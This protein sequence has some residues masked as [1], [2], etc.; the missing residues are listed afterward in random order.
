MRTG[1]WLRAA[2]LAG[3]ALTGAADA[4]RVYRVQPGDTLWSLAHANGTTVANLLAL[5]PRPAATLRAGEVILLPDREAADEVVTGEVAAPVT[6]AGAVQVGQAVYYPGRP[7]A[8]TAMTAAHLT[9]PKGTWVRVTHRVTGRSVDVLINDRG[10]FGV[11]SRIIDLSAAAA[12]K[13]GILSEGVA[14]VTVAVLARP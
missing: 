7:D 2:L 14:P 13:L 11:P 6:P 1:G 3:A 9:L 10:P 12:Q 5:N 4:N 8:T